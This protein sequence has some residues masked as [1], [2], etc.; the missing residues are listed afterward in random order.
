MSH[1]ADGY[2]PKRVPYLSISRAMVPVTPGV[3]I[4]VPDIWTTVLSDAAPHDHTSWPLNTISG[5]NRPSSVGPKQL[6]VVIPSLGGQ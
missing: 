6:K 1:A 3:A 4:E 5:F 2:D